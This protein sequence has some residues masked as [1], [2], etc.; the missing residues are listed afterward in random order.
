QPADPP[1]GQPRFAGSAINLWA[2][3]SDPGTADLST[4]KVQWKVVSTNGQ[5]VPGGTGVAFS[6]TPS[7]A[8]TYVVTVTATDKDGGS[9]SD[10][11]VL[12]VNSLT[13]TVAIQQA[14]AQA[15]EGTQINLTS[16]V[17]GGTGTLT[18]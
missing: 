9:A 7:G 18:Y 3:V 13:P 17:S 15:L 5:A 11:E 10:T 16:S 12:T 2:A 4:M 8:G 1:L 14:P 6:F